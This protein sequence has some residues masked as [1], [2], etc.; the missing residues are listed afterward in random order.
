MNTLTEDDLQ[1]HVDVVAKVAQDNLTSLRTQ[2]LNIATQ[3]EGH[4]NK[5]IEA[6]QDVKIT[7]EAETYGVDPSVLLVTPLL[8]S[9]IK[10]VIQRH[11]LE[12]D[13]D[14]SIGYDDH[15]AQIDFS[16]LSL[17]EVYNIQQGVVFEIW[18]R[19]NAI[20][21]QATKQQRKEKLCKALLKEKEQ[22]L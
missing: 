20:S 13:V 6:I 17:E 9:S 3:V 15:N 21:Y 1:K 16:K 4:L 19:E 22:E 18:L 7:M 11:A 2:Q 8:V 14:I 5:L 10:V 12:E